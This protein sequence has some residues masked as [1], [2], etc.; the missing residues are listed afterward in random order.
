MKKKISVVL[1]VLVLALA[2]GTSAAAAVSPYIVAPEVADLSQGN[3]NNAEYS[4][5]MKVFGEWHTANGYFNTSVLDGTDWAAQRNDA[6]LNIVKTYAGI[7][8]WERADVIAFMNVSAKNITSEMWKAGIKISLMDLPSTGYEKFVVFHIT[9]EGMIEVIPSSVE[10]GRIIGTFHSLSPV[11]VIGLK[12][13]FSS[14]TSVDATATDSTGAAV[15]LEV[16]AGDALAGANAAEAKGYNGLFQTWQDEEGQKALADLGEQLKAGKITEKAYREKQSEILT[17]CL[18][19]TVSRHSQV[20]FDTIQWYGEANISLTEG[21][22]MP[23]GGLDITIR[24]PQIKRGSRMILLH[25]KDDG[26]VEE[27]RNLK[28]TDGAI[29]GH[30]TSLSPVVYF[31][32]TSQ[33]GSGN[34]AGI[35]Q[36]AS[37]TQT[38]TQGSGSTAQNT[39]SP[40][41]G[42][43][44]MTALAALAALMAAGG[45]AYLGRRRFHA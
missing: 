38:G 4:T 14:S 9:S 41:T 37:G 32:V 36:P 10:N 33:A 1:A 39:G 35:Q 34:Q 43:H 18:K 13:T 31:E 42:E 30:F 24:D 29:T 11:V 2:M 27:I 26:T 12:G 40:K 3:M 19:E 45:V 16:V 20:K 25:I 8:G 15:K 22:A 17:K 5:L 44:D 6:A 23:K 28:V 7:S 21:G